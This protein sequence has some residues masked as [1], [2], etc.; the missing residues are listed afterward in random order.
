MTQTRTDSVTG[1]IAYSAAT[2]YLILSSLLSSVIVAAANIES[3]S[4]LYL[5]LS[6]LAAPIALVACVIT[7]LKVRKIPLKSVAPVKCKPKYYL[8]GLMLIFGLLFSLNWVNDITVKFFELFGYERKDPSMYFPSLEGFS[9]VPALL[10]IAVIP[11]IC[12]ELLF[13]GVILNSCERG[14]GSV[15]TVFIVGFCFSLFHASPEQTVYQFIAGCAFAFLAVRSRSLMP[16]VVIHFI[17]N[18]II[19]VF[20]AC[21]L[22][23][24][25]GALAIPAEV[26]IAL[27]V[28]GG[29]CLVAGLVWLILDKAPLVKGEKGGVAKFFIFASVGIIILAVLWL[30]AFFGV[31]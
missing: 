29:C 6:Y 18:A 27:T 24:A 14:A 8:I 16:S 13:R 1:G 12:E 19:V 25:E 7:V 20:A 11:A 30:C 4:D 15:R 31:G 9:V 21:G 22:F 2:L 28:V 23:D 3:T 17:N 10:V 26:E 5:Y